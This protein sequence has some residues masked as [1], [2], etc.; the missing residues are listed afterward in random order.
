[1]RRPNRTTAIRIAAVTALVVVV[2][3]VPGGAHDGKPAP[4]PPAAATLT[5]PLVDRSV[6][7]TATA[8]AQRILAT[9]ATYSGMALA[10]AEASVRGMASIEA[11]DRLVS[12]LDADLARLAAGY[13]GGPTRI[14]EGFLATRE[15][16]TGDDARQVEVWFA[17]VVAPPGRPVYAEWRL[18]TLGLLWERDGWRLNRFDDAPGPRPVALPGHADASEAIVSALDGF[19]AAGA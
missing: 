14:W 8:A 12:E 16:D 15:S 3:V 10:E 4:H 11:M 5:T 18:A 6:R 19:A 9:Y 1:M 7:E 17:R 2:R 13:P